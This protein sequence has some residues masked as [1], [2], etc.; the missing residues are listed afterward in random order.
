MIMMH[1]HDRYHE[2]LGGIRMYTHIYLI[3]QVYARVRIRIFV[4]INVHELEFTGTRM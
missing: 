3:L 2:G 4:Q 1:D